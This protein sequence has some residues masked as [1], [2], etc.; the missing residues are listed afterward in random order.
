MKRFHLR[1]P[2]AVAG[3]LQGVCWLLEPLLGGVIIVF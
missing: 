3:A 2:G 1:T